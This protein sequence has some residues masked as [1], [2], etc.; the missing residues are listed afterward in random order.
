M[1]ARFLLAGL[2]TVVAVGQVCGQTGAARSENS[3]PPAWRPAGETTAATPATADSPS[4]SGARVTGGNG[5]LPNQHGQVWREYDISPYTVRVTSTKRPEQALVDWILRETGYEAWHSQP[6]GILSA[7][8]RTLYVYH[9]P[10]MQAVVAGLVDRFVSSQAETSTFGLRVVT[11]DHPNWRARAHRLMRPVPVQTPGVRAWL[12]QKED[13]AVLMAE[14]H[15]RNDYRE[16]S[17]PHLMVNNG[18]STVVSAMRGR[19]YVQDVLLRSDVW[20]GFEAEMGQI[21]E[22]FSLEFSPLLSANR[23][24]IDATIKCNIDQVEKMFPVMIDVPTSVAKRQRTKIEVPQLIHFRFHERF[25]WPVD[26]VLLVGMG[27]VALPVP[28]DS[29]PL[30]RGLPLPLGSTPARADLLVFVEAKGRSGEAPRVARQP[31][32]EAKTYKG[33]Y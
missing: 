15:R 20:P 4:R 5:T 31:R 22:G 3:N 18:Q 28:V 10:E 1:L 13:A 23:Q 8:R 9:T 26:Q 27:M 24:M 32:D 30:V 17:S 12:L 14:L 6:L 7:G 11:V 2:A 16:H 21:D 25:R 33:R 29:K 19:P